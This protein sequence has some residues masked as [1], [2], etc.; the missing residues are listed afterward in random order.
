MPGRRWPAAVS[1]RSQSDCTGR[2]QHRHQRRSGHARRGEVD[3][4]GCQ[5]RH[6]AGQSIHCSKSVNTF[7]FRSRIP[8]LA[9]LADILSS[10]PSIPS[11]RPKAPATAWD[12][13]TCYSIIKRHGGIIEVESSPTRK[14][15]PGLPAD[16]I[17]R[18]RSLDAEVP[19]EVRHRGSGTVLVVDDE[20]VVQETIAGML[21]SFGYRVGVR[22]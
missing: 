5:R 14:H 4:H 19:G 2:R 15:I 12:W 22:E 11:I 7:A 18:A 3:H 6:R 20:E 10:G 13:A 17:P 8:A 1:V 21:R 9:C 16:R